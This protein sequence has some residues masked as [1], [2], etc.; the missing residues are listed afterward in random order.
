MADLAA[1]QYGVVTRTQLIELGH[2]EE[3]IDHDLG[4]GRLQ[5]WHRDVLALG[6]QGMSPHGLCMAT[7]LFRGPGALISHQS[8]IWLWGLETKLDVPVRV[9]LAVRVEDIAETE[10]LPVTAV[11]RSLLDYA[12][13]A[14]RWRLERA[15]A[16]ADRLGLLDLTAVNRVTDEVLD[17]CGRDPLLRAMAAYAERGFSRPSAERSMLAA[18]GAAGVRRPAVRNSVEGYELDFFWG[19]ERLGIELDS[20]EHQPPRRSF[21]EDRERR[22]NLALAGVRTVRITGTRLRREP[23]Q[24]ANRIA[25]ELDR[26]ARDEVA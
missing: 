1:R 7:V 11:P 2:T 4:A 25:E 16:K 9:G 17:H 22:E 14:R 5:A 19:P 10:R 12:A 26:R 18:L 13:D 20:W 3:T 23:R 15:I 21:E 24:V 8:A 6:G